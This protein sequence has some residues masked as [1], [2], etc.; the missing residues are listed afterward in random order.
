MRAIV[1]CAAM[2]VAALAPACAATDVCMQPRVDT[3]TC[4]SMPQPAD[5]EACLDTQ[6]A[7]RVCKSEKNPGTG[8]A[9]GPVATGSSQ[10]EACDHLLRNDKGEYSAG[11][12]VCSEGSGFWRCTLGD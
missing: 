6:K 4:M 10:S 2:I 7:Q 8:T 12:C 5:R 3:G 1:A 11:K 9:G